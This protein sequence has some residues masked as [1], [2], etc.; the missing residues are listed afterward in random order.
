[1]MQVFDRLDNSLKITEHPVMTIGVFDGVHR[2]HQAIL[3]R[4]V[5]RAREKKGTS[6]VLTFSPHPRKVISPNQSPLVLQTLRQKE[7]L[8]E[9]HSV[10]VL[11]R[12]PFTQELSLLS[13]E[14]FLRQ[15]LSTQRIREIYVGDNFRFGHRRAGTFRT[16]QMLGEKFQFDAYSIMPVDFRGVRISLSLLH[17]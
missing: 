13:P 7:R 14:E 10:D 3:R 5:D 8:I 4:T 15:I 2:G 12:L 11:F 6:I 9:K 1:M 16:L 17:I